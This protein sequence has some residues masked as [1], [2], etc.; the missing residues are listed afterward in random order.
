MSRFLKSLLAAAVALYL[1]AALGMYAFQ[2]QLM[3]HPGAELLKP[4]AYGLQN[5][6]AHSLITPDGET[7]TLWHAEAAPGA[8]T[9][10]YLHGNAGTLAQ[11]ARKL[12]QIQAA[13]IGAAFLSWRG[14]GTSTG[15]PS[16]TGLIT[17]A[18]TAYDWLRAQNIPA[19]KIAILGES[20]GTG[21][22]IQLAA[23]NDTGALLL[24]APYTATIDIA[25]SR[26]PWLP[27]RLL[28]KDQ[29]KSRDHIAR[30]A[31][32]IHIAHGTADRVIPYAQGQALAALAT[33]PVTFLTLEGRGHETTLDSAVTAQEIAFL[34]RILPQP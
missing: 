32:P 27:L 16:E 10:L 29:F 11:R 20:L 24:S 33:A 31:A 34:T 28:M 22:A 8:P 23:A 25:Q 14:F 17:D 7:L 18:Q 30:V 1:L 12:A 4:A 21:P 5:V 13:G 19:Q 26:F 6:T 15:S 3:Y 2:R 9:L